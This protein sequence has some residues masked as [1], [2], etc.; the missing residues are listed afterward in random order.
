VKRRKSIQEWMLYDSQKMKYYWWMPGRRWMN[1]WR[2]ANAQPKLPV[3]LRFRPRR[4]ER[5]Y[6]WRSYRH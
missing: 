5:I 3:G 4:M 6:E 2:M 1:G